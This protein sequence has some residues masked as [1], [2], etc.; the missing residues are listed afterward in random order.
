M[1]CSI[2]EKDVV[3][4]N[5][6]NLVITW[7]VVG[8]RHS[9]RQRD[10]TLL[11][12]APDAPYDTNDTFASIKV[13]PEMTLMQIVA[14]GGAMSSRKFHRVAPMEGG[15]DRLTKRLSELEAVNC[16]LPATRAEGENMGYGVTMQVFEFV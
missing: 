3:D 15:A 11:L 9:S 14:L 6:L 4:H 5:P 2:W 16:T 12:T 8:G 1:E 10:L 7:N 13:C